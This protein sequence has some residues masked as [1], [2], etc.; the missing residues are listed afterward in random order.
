MCLAPPVWRGL[1][2]RNRVSQ[3]I[4]PKTTMLR[5]SA[6]ALPVFCPPTAIKCCCRTS[7]PRSACSLCIRS[8]CPPRTPPDPRFSSALQNRQS[9]PARAAAHRR[10]SMRRG[11]ANR[12]RASNWRQPG[13]FHR[14]PRGPPGQQGMPSR[15][16]RR[17]EFFQYF[18]SDLQLTAIHV[19][20]PISTSS[21][22]LKFKCNFWDHGP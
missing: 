1:S 22:Y 21:S 11:S 14:Q 5:H 17:R 3:R 19:L 15:L 16:R 6:G 12:R 2:L 4:V 8:C 18:S 7:I 10:T 13:P 9:P 20:I